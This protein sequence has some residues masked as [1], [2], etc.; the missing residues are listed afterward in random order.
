MSNLQLPIFQTG[1]WV[2]GKTIN[3]EMIQG[4]IH[5]IHPQN[6]TIQ[7]YVTISDHK[8][9]IG[10]MIETFVHR[11]EP[12]PKSIDDQEG[13]LANLIDIALLTKDREWF[14]EVWSKLNNLKNSKEETMPC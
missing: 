9:I 2:K 14:M 5:S 3:D 1:E 8:E 7:L 6:G 13:Y 10:K 4:Y 12:L 11:I